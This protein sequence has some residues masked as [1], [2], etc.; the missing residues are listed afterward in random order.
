[1]NLRVLGVYVTFVGEYVDSGEGVVV[2][3]TRGDTREDEVTSLGLEE[4]KM[5]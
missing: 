3:T 4:M 5:R 1:M 2:P